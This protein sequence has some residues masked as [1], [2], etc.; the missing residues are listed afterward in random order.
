M[1]IYLG[2]TWDRRMGR[3]AQFANTSQDFEIQDLVW[4]AVKLL[5]SL[6]L[7]WCWLHAA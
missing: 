1:A 6:R 7:L 3:Y 2:Q 5:T 4:F